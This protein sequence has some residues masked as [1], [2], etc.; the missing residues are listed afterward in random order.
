[1]AEAMVFVRDQMFK[2]DNGARDNMPRILIIMVS[3]NSDLNSQAVFVAATV[4]KN[5]FR[6]TIIGVAYGPNLRVNELRQIVSSPVEENI[7]STEDSRNLDMKLED[8]LKKLCRE[9]PRKWLQKFYINYS[10]SS[11]FNRT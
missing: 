8:T 6:I 5:D 10:S 2:E 3:T 1:M 9:I 11:S 7:F 4:A